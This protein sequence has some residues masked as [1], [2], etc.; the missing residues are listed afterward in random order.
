MLTENKSYSQPRW[1]I[2]RWL[3]NAGPGVPE[4]IRIAL[5]GRL[6]GTLPVFAA[7]AINTIAVAAAAAIR[8]P[9]ALFIAW[10]IL[11]IVICL[12]RL[13]V[14]IIAHRR[15]RAHRKTPTDLHLLL[16][17][18]WSMSVG[19]GAMISLA[20]GDRVIALLAC[21]SAAAMVGGICFRNFFAPRLAGAMILFSLGPILPGIALAGDPLLY[22][23]YLQAPLYLWAMTAASFRLNKMQ[24]ATMRSER[25]HVHLAHHDSL[26]GLLNR[27]GFIEALVSEL[28]LAEDSGEKRSALLFLDLDDFKPV[29]DTYGHQAGD[30]LLGLVAARLRQALPPTDVIARLGGDEFVVLASDVGADEAL[31]IAYRIID[32]LAASYE[33]GDGISAS[34]GASVG[35]AM[36]PEHGTEAELLLAVADIALYEAKSSGKSRCC[37][38]SAET[39]LAALRRINEDSASAA[40]GVGM[41]A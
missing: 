29:N 38:A 7:G 4:D 34:I 35:I 17:V 39:S 26:T 1:P 18:A 25:E 21:V 32:A 40:G 9:V 28:D 10:L 6:H 16:A 19:F 5:I 11:E 3:G 15:A 37:I 8:H 33:L 30:R 27:I 20:S 36:S 14:L 22:V 13:I 41:A 12:A 24:I 23:G 31:A 2:A